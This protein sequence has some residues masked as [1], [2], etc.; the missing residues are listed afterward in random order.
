MY[1]C[2]A[3]DQSS[4][5]S[6]TGFWPVNC[7]CRRHSRFGVFLLAPNQL[8]TLFPVAPRQSCASQSEVLALRDACV[9]G[10]NS[11]NSNETQ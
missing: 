2:S 1:K 6:V 9:D 10:W 3:L 11:A 8:V 7:M 4:T 5:A